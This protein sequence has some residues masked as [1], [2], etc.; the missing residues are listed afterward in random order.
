MIHHKDSF[1]TLDE[2]G[3]NLLPYYPTYEFPNEYIDSAHKFFTTCPTKD[4]LIQIKSHR[5]IVSIIADSFLGENL[6]YTIL[7][8]IHYHIYKLKQ[9]RLAC[10]VFPESTKIQIRNYFR[11]GGAVILGWLGRA[12]A[13]KLYELG[14]FI[15]KDILEL[16]SCNG[17]S[18]SILSQANHNSP[19]KKRIYSVDLN[20]SHVKITDCTLRSMGL[21][22][23]VITNCDDAVSSVKKF[24]SQ[25]KIFEF[26]F[27]DHS[28]EYE[29]TYG[30]CR[31]LKH[32]V[33]KGGFCLFH[34]FNNPRNRD[35]D[36]TEYDVYK[37]IMDGLDKNYFEFYGI[38]GTCALY[39]AI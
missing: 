26:V 4:G 28:H 5:G 10:S 30:V 11:F 17:L 27:I 1:L 38:Y 16:G 32:I 36:D 2:L 12:E 3:K 13:L 14:Y 6:L 25:G 29:P 39:R 20:Q 37:A 8:R 31:E 9:G 19:Y 33:T 23:D 15:S 34:D 35:P 22:K 21:A 7:G 24:S 18:T